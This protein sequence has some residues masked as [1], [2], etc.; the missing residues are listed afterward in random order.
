M[1]LVTLILGIAA[2]I[3]SFCKLDCYILFGMSIISL[4]FAQKTGDKNYSTISLLLGICCIG[5]GIYMA[6]IFWL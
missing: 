3:Y 2:V 1:F 4:A 5:L 6:F